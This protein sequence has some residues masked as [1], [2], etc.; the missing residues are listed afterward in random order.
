MCHVQT[1]VCDDFKRCFACQNLYFSRQS[2][3]AHRRFSSQHLNAEIG[4]GIVFLY[5]LYHSFQERI[6]LFRLLHRIWFDNS[7]EDSI[8]SVSLHIDDTLKFQ[9]QLFLA[10]WFRDIIHS[11]CAKSLQTHF[12]LCSRRDKQQWDMTRFW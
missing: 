3:L 6:H 4:I 10:E 8:L 11:T 9:K 1:V 2:R 5:H 12:I 7:R